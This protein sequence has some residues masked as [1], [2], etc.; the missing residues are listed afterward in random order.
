G[1]P[2]ARLHSF[3][4]FGRPFGGSHIGSRPFT[5]SHF[6]HSIARPNVTNFAHSPGGSL[7][8][9]MVG[10]SRPAA[11]H[12]SRAAFANMGH[13]N[14]ALRSRALF[15][16]VARFNGSRSWAHSAFAG[17]WAGNRFWWHRHRGFVIGWFWP[18]FWPYLYDDISDYTYWP[19][20]YD[21]F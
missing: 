7:R 4:S 18:L 12:T 10:V 5:G 15:N 13:V 6:S 3:H 21:E 2:G 17:R 19:Y 14:P 1:F 11:L 8:H 20:A 9:S 16:P